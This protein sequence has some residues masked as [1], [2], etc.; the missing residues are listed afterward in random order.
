MNVASTTASGITLFTYDALN[1]LAS[2]STSPSSTVTATTSIAILDTLPLTFHSLPAAPRSPSPT[3][4]PQA[5]RNKLFVVLI[6]KNGVDPPTATLNGQSLTISPRISGSYDRAQYYVGYL[7]NPS[8]GTFQINFTA[9]TVA[10][11]EVFTLQNAAQSSPIDV[12]YV[13]TNQ[14][15]SSL[16]TS[17]TTTQGNDFLASIDFSSA[18]NTL[19][20]FGAS[21]TA[22]IANDQDPSYLGPITA[23]GSGP[24]QAPAPRR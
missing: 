3:R 20:S 24:A 10:D 23:R 22:L 21:E 14:P 9:T 18:P 8:S 1:R 5:A 16:S 6:G 15:A 17:V 13:T 19:S 11:Y 2:A 4:C 7:A 12:S